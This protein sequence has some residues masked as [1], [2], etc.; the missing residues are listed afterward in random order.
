MS[1]CTPRHNNCYVNQL[2]F[3]LFKNKQQLKLVSFELPSSCFLRL[4]GEEFR[5][6]KQQ[7]R[8]L[9]VLQVVLVGAIQLLV[10]QLQQRHA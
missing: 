9:A 7:T 3:E 8:R 5:Q 1:D 10:L 4:A 2:T 6:G